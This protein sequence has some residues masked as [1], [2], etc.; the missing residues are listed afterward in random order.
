MIAFVMPTMG[1]PRLAVKDPFAGPPTR[2]PIRLDHEIA[3]HGTKSHQTPCRLVRSVAKRAPYPISRRTS[4]WR[5]HPQS[6]RQSGMS[7][8]AEY[9]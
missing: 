4:E 9:V 5:G 7:Y 8:S 3:L 2:H 6:S 1:G